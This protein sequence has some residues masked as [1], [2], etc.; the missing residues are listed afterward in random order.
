V[1]TREAAELRQDQEG[2]GA[3]LL[4]N[5]SFRVGADINHA[6]LL[7]NNNNPL[8]HGM[9][10]S[11]LWSPPLDFIF[12]YLKEVLA[13]LILVIRAHISPLNQIPVVGGS[14]TI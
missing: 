10:F 6:S 11:I 7:T 1:S 13:W 2:R 8:W 14:Y 9:Y 5:V 12:M 3:F 4:V